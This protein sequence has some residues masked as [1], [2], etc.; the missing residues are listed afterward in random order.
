MAHKEGHTGFTTNFTDAAMGG[1]GSG[2]LFGEGGFRQ[3]R[4]DFVS[5]YGMTPRKYKKAYGGLPSEGFLPDERFGIVSSPNI[6]QNA[7]VVN[8]NTKTGNSDTTTTNTNQSAETRLDEGLDFTDSIYNNETLSRNS[9]IKSAEDIVSD[10][11][12][13]A[14][15]QGTGG[16]DTGGGKGMGMTSAQ[17]GA[18]GDMAGGVASIISGIT[19]GGKRR[20]EQAAAQAEYNTM[21]DRFDNLS[22]ANV[23][24]NMN[25]PYEDLTVNQ[26]QADFL[27]QQQQQGLANTMRSLQGA[28][29]GSGI[30]ALAQAMANQQ[31]Q[32]LQQASASIGQQEAA[33]QRLRAQ[34]AMQVQMAERQ[35]ELI[36]NQMEAQKT[37]TQLGRAD[38]RLREANLA[39]EQATKALVGGVAQLGM[40]VATGGASGMFGNAWFDGSRQ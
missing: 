3:A 19:G 37:A 18:I 1:T 40:G 24:R 30:A 11:R 13:N 35:G 12:A 10:Y 2:F 26:Q 4:K 36:S 34:G 39:R 23:Y 7:F 28:A 15:N 33:N 20:A 14:G 25:N 9:D 31:G 27:A 6:D 5:E 38:E 17:M 21:K 32:N 8:T 29:G 16:D 22:T